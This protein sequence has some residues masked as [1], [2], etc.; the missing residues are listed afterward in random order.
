[1]KNYLLLFLLTISH[2]ALG[3]KAPSVMFDPPEE[4][5]TSV[6]PLEQPSVGD[7]CEALL[8]E[9]EALK[10][11]PQRRHSARE[12]YRLECSQPDR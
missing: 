5:I 2:H 8:R 1:M 10:G 11:K 9:I 12:R 4:S 7:R 6:P 3:E